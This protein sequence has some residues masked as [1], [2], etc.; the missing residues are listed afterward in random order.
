[1]G[2]WNLPPRYHIWEKK[3]H[4]ITNPARF[5]RIVARATE[6]RTTGFVEYMDNV[7]QRIQKSQRCRRRSST[8]ITTRR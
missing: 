6:H 7:L 3:G 8:D 5:H 2:S 1:V 4:Q